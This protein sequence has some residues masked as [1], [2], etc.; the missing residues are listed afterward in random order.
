MSAVWAMHSTEYT[1]GSTGFTREVA[2]EDLPLRVHVKSG[3]D[4]HPRLHLLHRVH[5]QHGV[6]VGNES[7]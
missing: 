6:P 1:P 4:A 5:Q 7:P 2:A 3:H